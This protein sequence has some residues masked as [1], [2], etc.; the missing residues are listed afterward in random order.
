ME[1]SLSTNILQAEERA[2]PT[3]PVNPLC[4]SDVAETAIQNITAKTA[5]FPANTAK[6]QMHASH[7]CAFIS[8]AT[9]TWNGE[10]SDTA[11]TDGWIQQ[12][13]LPNL[14]CKQKKKSKNQER[15]K[16]EHTQKP[17]SQQNDNGAHTAPHQVNRNTQ[18][19]TTRATTVF[20]PT[21]PHNKCLSMVRLWSSWTLAQLPHSDRWLNYISNTSR[22]AKL[23]LK[24]SGNIT[25]TSSFTSTVGCIPLYNEKY[26][27]ACTEWLQRSKEASY[28]TG[29]NFRLALLQRS[30]QDVA[31]V[32][33]S[34]DEELSHDKLIEEIMC[35]ILRY[36]QHCS[37]H[38]WTV[39]YMPATWPKTSSSTST[40]TETSTG[41]A[42]RSCHMKK[43]TSPHSAQF[44]S[45]LQDPIGKKTLWETMGWQAELQA[46][47]STEMLWQGHKSLQAVQV[48]EHRRELEVFETSMEINETTHHQ[49][50]NT[51][52]DSTTNNYNNLNNSQGHH[53]QQLQKEN[54]LTIMAPKV[55]CNFC[56]G[57]REIFQ[58]SKLL[59]QHADNPNP[60]HKGEDS[61]CHHWIHQEQDG[62]LC[63]H[64][65]SGT[66]S[67]G[68]AHGSSHWACDPWEWHVCFLRGIGSQWNLPMT[69][70][71]R[72]MLWPL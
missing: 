11:S 24:L 71:V 62:Q 60:L 45:L 67:P 50:S 66:R 49:K 53:R 28:Y 38:W 20:L 15:Q 54:Q 41:G 63:I 40:N 26:K 43:H 59:D 25:S 56:F 69:R 51:K 18:P 55:Q 52:M 57:P 72:V 46:V 30:S 61:K 8:R 68:W 19:T 44:C 37:S 7:C 2:K 58:I 27:D 6:S 1:L 36:P 12:T 21:A 16:R 10:T 29:Y 34:L 5:K 47:K 65:Q 39:P 64:W 23:R 48:T 22:Q 4:V 17:Q 13:H 33:R 14:P 3:T 32:I 35:C 70:Q 9:S 31:K 42:P